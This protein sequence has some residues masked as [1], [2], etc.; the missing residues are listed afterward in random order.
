MGQAKNRWLEQQELGFNAPGWRHVCDE[1]VADYALK[2]LVRSHAAE[3]TCDFCDRT[4]DKPIAADADTVL[5]HIGRSINLEWAD[6]VGLLIF[7]KEDDRWVGRVLDFEEVLAEEFMWP[8]ANERFER[9]TVDAFSE[10]QWT[11]VDPGGLNEAEALQFSWELFAETVKHKARFLFALL[12]EEGMSDEPGASLRRRGEMLIEIG[13]LVNKYDLI[14]V[15]SAET[16]L[17]RA[18]VHSSGQSY[19]TARDLGTPPADKARQSRMS[20]AGIPMFYG[21]EEADGALAE[22]VDWSRASGKIATIAS[23]QARTEFRV[24]DLDRLN[25]VPSI[26]DHRPAARR[27]RPSLGFMHGFRREVSRPIERDDRIHIEYVPTQAVTEYFRHL[28]R[29]NEGRSV[30]GFAYESTRAPG[31]RNVPLFV[32][33]DHCLERDER[34]PVLDGLVLEIHGRERRRVSE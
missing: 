24:V 33:N 21:A 9:F 16:P 29:D 5:E 34:E 6:P 3:P 18:R 8:F 4:S 11:E 26:F 22:T 7:D 25:D 28:F 15:F 20:P 27:D 17:F 30:D 2:H 10:S 12:D 23:F 32:D 14:T 31:R 13:N 1:C 19:T